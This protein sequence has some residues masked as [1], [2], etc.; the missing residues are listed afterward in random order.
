M[1]RGLFTSLK[2]PYVQFSAASTKGA[3]IFSL[4]RQ[5]VKHLG[6]TVLTVTCDGASN[7]QRMFQMFNSK[8]DLSHKIVNIFNAE[9]NNV[10]FISDPPHLLKTIGNCFA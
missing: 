7:N 3:D 8:A 9:I 1:V 4:I 5:A 6:L 10:F 2:Y